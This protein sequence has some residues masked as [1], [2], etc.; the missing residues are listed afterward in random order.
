MMV[1]VGWGEFVWKISWP[2]NRW[3][4]QIF[5]WGQ[6]KLRG[7][8]NFFYFHPYLGKWSNLTNIFQMGWNHQ[9]EKQLRRWYT[10]FCQVGIEIIDGCEKWFCHVLPVFRFCWGLDNQQLSYLVLLKDTCATGWSTTTTQM[11]PAMFGDW[12]WWRQGA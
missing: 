12:W 2:N 7:G 4:P 6:Q 11:C 3:N 10:C 1:N 9:L 5:C 8:F